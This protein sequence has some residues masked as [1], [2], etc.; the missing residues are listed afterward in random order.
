MERTAM[1]WPNSWSCMLAS[2]RKA[3]M[4]SC[5]CRSVMPGLL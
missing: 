4:S 3:A 1:R 2:P 5:F